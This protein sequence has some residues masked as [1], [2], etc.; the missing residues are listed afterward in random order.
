MLILEKFKISMLLKTWSCIGMQQV[1]HTHGKK[2]VSALVKKQ[3]H[4]VIL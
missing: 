3:N 2:K 1:A 4:N